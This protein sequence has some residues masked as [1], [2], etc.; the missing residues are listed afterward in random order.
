MP[1]NSKIYLYYTTFL[2]QYYIMEVVYISR[3]LEKDPKQQKMN[4]EEQRLKLKIHR[5]G[6][7]TI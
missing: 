1:T 7:C 4:A 2:T 6:I 3:L 5:A